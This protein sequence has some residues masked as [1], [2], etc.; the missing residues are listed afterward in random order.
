MQ[1]LKIGK[2]PANSE[3]QR[4]LSPE[5]CIDLTKLLPNI[6]S[7]VQ[8]PDASMDVNSGNANIRKCVPP[9][10]NALGSQAPPFYS[11]QPLQ[12]EQ[13]APDCT[14]SGVPVSFKF[15][16]QSLPPNVHIY[17]N[18]A[19]Y[20]NTQPLQGNPSYLGVNPQPQPNF[21][22][23]SSGN[24]NTAPDN[25]VDNHDQHSVK[26]AH[27]EVDWPVAKKNK[28]D[29]ES[30]QVT[31]YNA[32][33]L[34]KR[35][36]PKRR[37]KCIKKRTFEEQQKYHR[38]L[39]KRIHRARNFWNK[40]SH[41]YPFCFRKRVMNYYVDTDETSVNEILDFSKKVLNAEDSDD[42]HMREMDN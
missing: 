12:S 19:I 11:Q 21:T 15:N 30:S 8:L 9:N 3:E 22:P 27:P 38:L 14:I 37:C 24:M 1:K 32:K 17:M 10:L 34:N 4:A 29:S 33:Y 23:H 7:Q 28:E 42:E 39:N 18:I 25:E 41:S 5:V 31:P 35:S 26:T 40:T 6:Q 2:H 36:E 16:Q 13:P 20:V